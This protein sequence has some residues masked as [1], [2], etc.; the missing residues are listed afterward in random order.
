[1]YSL[2]S[3]KVFRIANLS[4]VYDSLLFESK[5]SPASQHL[6]N[7]D[8]N[9]RRCNTPTRVRQHARVIMHAVVALLYWSWHAAGEVQEQSPWFERYR[10]EFFRMLAFSEHECFDHPVACELNPLQIIIKP[11]AVSSLG[12]SCAMD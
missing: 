9:Y 12:G 8:D 6:V 5:S 3:K 2:A 1:M 7:S 4:V 11:L 10:Q